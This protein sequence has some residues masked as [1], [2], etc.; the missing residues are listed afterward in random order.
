MRWYEIVADWLDYG[1]DVYFLYYEELVADP[2]GELRSLLN[3]LHLPVDEDRL[4]CAHK[5]LAGIITIS[6]YTHG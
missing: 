3:H 5:H 6:T 4:T 1:R 2:L